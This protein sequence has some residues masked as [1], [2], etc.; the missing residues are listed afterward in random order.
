MTNSGVGDVQQWHS[1][2]VQESERPPS[3]SSHQGYLNSTNAQAYL[4]QAFETEDDR[5]VGD[6]KI[7]EGLVFLRRF[8]DSR[9]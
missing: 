9:A 1:K 4:E 8:Y 7:K 6:N 3:A 5:K 2:L